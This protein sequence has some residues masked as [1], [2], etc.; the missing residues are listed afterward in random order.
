MAWHKHQHIRLGD[1][2]AWLFPRRN[3]LGRPVDLGRVP[4]EVAE[5]AR[6]WSERELPRK[7]YKFKELKL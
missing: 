7:Y 4:P 6:I 2:K 5:A 3:D 1:P